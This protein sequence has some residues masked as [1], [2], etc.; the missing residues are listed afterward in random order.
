MI[1]L[2]NIFQNVNRASTKLLNKRKWLITGVFLIGLAISTFAQNQEEKTSKNGLLYIEADPLAYINK[3][4]SIHLGYENWGMRFDLTKVKVDFPESFEMAFYN[5]TAF[6]LISHINGV[7]VD[8]IGK[9]ENWTKG[10]FIGMDINHQI[11]DLTHRESN[12]KMD[13]TAFNIGVRAGYKFDI[14]KG[15]YITPWAAYWKNIAKKQT[16]NIKTDRITTN[17]FDWLVTFHLGYAI[18]F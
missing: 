1:R 4:Y 10:A 18:Q 16:F 14:Y 7:K 2:I 15:F 9:R 12:Q 11:L 8:Y 13:L 17:N 5:T 3:G 6:D